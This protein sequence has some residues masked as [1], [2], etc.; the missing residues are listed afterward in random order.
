MTDKKSNI[1]RRDILKGAGVTTAAL[2]AASLGACQ[3]QSGADPV[4]QWNREADIVV[5][6]SGVGAGTA[7]LTARENGDSVIMVDKAPVFGGTS[8]SVERLMSPAA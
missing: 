8:T 7:A 1:T 4:I 2:G 3:N 6:G 5:V